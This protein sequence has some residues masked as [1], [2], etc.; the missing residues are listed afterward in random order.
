MKVVCISNIGGD[1]REN[2]RGSLHVGRMALTIGKTYMT[3]DIHFTHHSY[4]VRDDWGRDNWF[5]QI[6]FKPLHEIRDE[7]LKE[8]GIDGE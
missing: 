4:V 7:K 1:S 2:M 8:L 5:S 3:S 6:H